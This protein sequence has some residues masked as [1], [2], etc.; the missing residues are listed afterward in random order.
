MQLRTVTWMRELAVR[1]RINTARTF[2]IQLK[3]TFTNLKVV[4]TVRCIYISVLYSITYVLAFS[5][6]SLKMHT[7]PKKQTKKEL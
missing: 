1:K 5:F 2:Y 3:M 7:V 6:S 4:Y